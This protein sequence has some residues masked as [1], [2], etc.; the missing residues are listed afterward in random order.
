LKRERVSLFAAW[1]VIRPKVLDLFYDGYLRLM[2][3]SIRRTDVVV[4]DID[5]TV[6]RQEIRL[7]R[8][9]TGERCDFRRANR[10]AE[11]LRDVPNVAAVEHARRWGREAPVVWLTARS[12]KTMLPT[13]LWLRSQGLPIHRIVF[14]GSTLR[15]IDF[16]DVHMS[17]G[18][19]I[20]LLVDD[21][22]EGHEREHPHLVEEYAQFVKSQGIRYFLSFDEIGSP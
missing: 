3:H 18:G 4:F 20:Q 19:Q 11:L 9:V 10:F 5:N 2:S 17:R 13:W 21:M 22:H 6:N 15:K 16:L 7:K 8:F 14:T 1:A 12:I